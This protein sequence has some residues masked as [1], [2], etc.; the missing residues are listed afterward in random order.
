MWVRLL[1]EKSRNSWNREHD[2]AR[3]LAAFQSM[4][5]DLK[6]WPAPAVFF[7]HL[8]AREPVRSKLGQKL[9][10]DWGRERQAEALAGMIQQF[11]DM[12]FDRNGNRIGA[13]P[14]KAKTVANMEQL[15][16]LYGSGMDRKAAAAGGDW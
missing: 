5:L 4:A 14:S 16:A 15:R 7:D 10:A 6:H 1:W 9:D 12:G 11:A 3:I 8:P 2:E 13:P